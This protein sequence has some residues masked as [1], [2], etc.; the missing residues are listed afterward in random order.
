M[1][2]CHVKPCW[3]QFDGCCAGSLEEVEDDDSHVVEVPELP[4]CITDWLIYM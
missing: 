4:C 2:L 3:N 1:R